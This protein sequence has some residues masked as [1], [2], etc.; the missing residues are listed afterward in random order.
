MSLSAR[1]VTS[2][3]SI[4]GWEITDYLGV[5]ATHVVAGTGFVSD[6][7]ASWS[8]LFGG[9]SDAYQ[10]Q[11][12]SLYDDAVLRIMRKARDAG[13][14]WVVAL[15]LDI[16]EVSGKGVQMFMVTAIGTAVRAKPARPDRV[17]SV[18][19]TTVDAVAVKV[20]QERLRLSGAIGAGNLVL[21]DKNWTFIV[22]H[23]VDEAAPAVLGWLGARIN[24]GVYGTVPD[25]GALLQRPR[26]FFRSLERTVA[27]RL[28]Y[29]A[30]NGPP[31]PAKAALLLIQD[32]PLAS[33]EATASALG[34]QSPDLRCRALQ[35]LQA[36]QPDYTV[37]DLSRFDSLVAAIPSAFPSMAVPVTARGLLGGA[38]SRWQCGFCGKSANTD[39]DHYCRDCD[40]DACGFAR[41]ELTANDAVTL[42]Q[43]RRGA[44][45]AVLTQHSS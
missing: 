40:R 25:Q 44:L 33:L 28:L 41:N 6:W 15:R 14:N 5:V 38:K 20:M 35:T 31:S 32:L 43:D 11:L 2:T 1:N 27:T 9:R 4:E 29:A 42:L 19:A 3:G 7:L 36:D 13:G 23:A 8:D 16:D 26:A 34:D 10:N 45:A 18:P 17:E 30:L 21:D 12:A 22:E 37:E 39:D 24:S